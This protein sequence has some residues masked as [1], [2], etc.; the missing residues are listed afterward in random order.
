MQP[1]HEADD[2]HALLQEEYGAPR[3]DDQFSADLIARLQAEAAPS[4]TP[5][6]ARRTPLAICLGVAAVAVLVIAVIGIS[7][8]GTP[9][10]NH[11]LARR[12]KTDSHPAARPVE[13]TEIEES[14]RND[15]VDNT[16]VLSGR[17]SRSESQG[18]VWE[19]APDPCAVQGEARAFLW[20]SEGEALMGESEAQ[21]VT[22]ESEVTDNNQVGEVSVIPDHHKPWRN[23]SAM[24]AHAGMLYVVDSGRLCEVS[25]IDGSRRIVGDDD[26]QNPAAMG[27]GIGHLYIVSDNQLYEVNPTTGARRSLGKPDWAET[28]AIVTVGDEL[29]IVAGGLLHRINPEEGSHEVLHRRSDGTNDP[30]NPKQ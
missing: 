5:T 11:E 27:A 15:S 18:F 17:E 16:G 1:D 2:L 30:R 19:S 12:A 29:Y 21:V 26:W 8:R 7:N 13:S 14:V 24:V 9:E 20:E 28:K 22:A 6:R 25:P 4:S 23:I 10:T 3:L